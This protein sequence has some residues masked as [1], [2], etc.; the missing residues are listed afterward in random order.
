MAKATIGKGRC[1][2]CNKE[3]S[4]VKCQGCSQLFCF[5][6]LPVH[7]E[8]LNLQLD[9]IVLDR[10]L[11]QE[12]FN[13]QIYNPQKHSL[14]KQIDKWK[15]ESIIKIQRTAN[16]FKRLILHHTIGHFKQIKT[17]LDRL[18]NQLR[19]IRRENDF[20]EIEIK[21]FKQKI[22]QLTEELHKPS[23]VSIQEDIDASLISKISV[24]VSS[25]KYFLIF[26][27]VHLKFS[28]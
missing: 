6:H 20:N 16:E 26:I 9:N 1:V 8:K 3:K 23:N 17:K 2:M 22:E 13:E 7:R 11:F 21:N 25:S 24:I 15:E 5:D 12:A 14:I 10:D 4:A 18:T 28:L 19:E 27:E